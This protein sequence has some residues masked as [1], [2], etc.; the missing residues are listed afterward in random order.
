MLRDSR[1]AVETLV[2]VIPVQAGIQKIVHCPWIPACAGMTLKNVFWGQ[3]ALF[4]I[5][6]FDS[7]GNQSTTGIIGKRV[8]SVNKPARPKARPIHLAVPGLGV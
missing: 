1:D 5:A 3:T 6:T 7:A 4:P 2:K 8:T